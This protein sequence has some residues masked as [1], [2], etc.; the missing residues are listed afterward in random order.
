M[1][2]QKRFPKAIQIRVEDEFVEGGQHIVPAMLVGE[3]I[4]VSSDR[5]YLEI[6][7]VQGEAEGE[8][9]ELL[10]TME[11]VF[12]DTGQGYQFEEFVQDATRIPFAEFM[13]KYVS[14]FI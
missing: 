2:E 9:Y 14:L 13:G 10:G 4:A 3:R 5:D 12:F 8:M 7:Y 11:P 1:T 6:H